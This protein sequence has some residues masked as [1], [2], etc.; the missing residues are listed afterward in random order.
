MRRPKPSSPNFH[1]GSAGLDSVGLA[2]HDG[3][4]TMSADGPDMDGDTVK[5]LAR[6]NGVDIDDDAAEIVAPMI[7]AMLAV[8]A[9]LRM[10]DLGAIPA[11][12]DLW[13]AKPADA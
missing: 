9:K 3:E 8:D 13:G 12:G 10:M 2:P 1:N 11:S 5:R 4:P 6:L 7:A